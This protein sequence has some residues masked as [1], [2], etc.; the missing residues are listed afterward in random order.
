MAKK[1]KV[2]LRLSKEVAIAN[3]RPELVEMDY[4]DV[5]KLEFDIHNLLEHKQQFIADVCRGLSMDTNLLKNHGIGII[6]NVVVVSHEL[7]DG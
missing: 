5:T 6:R 3:N 7:G 4:D 1:N 2:Q